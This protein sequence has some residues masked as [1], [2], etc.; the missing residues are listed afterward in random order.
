[1]VG[2]PVDGL[3]NLVKQLPLTFVRIHKSFL[4]RV[5]TYIRTSLKLC[6]T[7]ATLPIDLTFCYDF[8]KRMNSK[9]KI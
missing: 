1:M 6:N 9:M 7:N 4:H 8:I 2:I 5:A 3:K